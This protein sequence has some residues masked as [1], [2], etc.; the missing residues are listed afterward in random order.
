MPK[1]WLAAENF[2]RRK[3]LSAK[4]FVRRNILSAKILNIPWTIKLYQ[5]HIISIS[6]R[7]HEES[8]LWYYF[9]V[10]NRDDEEVQDPVE[11]PE[12]KEPW[13]PKDPVESAESPENWA[14]QGPT[15]EM[16]NQESLVEMEHQ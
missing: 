4:N 13:E 10:F 9:S 3:F 16:E 15:D 1:I 11:F 6:I 14:N 5:N 12:N 2:V 7:Y 8:R